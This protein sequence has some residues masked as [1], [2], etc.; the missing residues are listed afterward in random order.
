[1]S[2][3]L[4]TYTR[5]IIVLGVSVLF[6]GLREWQSGDAL[7]Y[8]CYLILAILASSLRVGLNTE[9]GSF[10]ISYLFILVGVVSLHPSETLALAAAV[11][12]TQF[13]ADR[14]NRP[15]KI[16]KALYA[17]SVLTIAT[18]LADTAVHTPLIELQINTPVSNAVRLMLVGCAFFVGHSFP[19]ATREAL[20]G[21]KNIGRIWKTEW[22][23]RLPY[24]M[25]AAGA[26][27]IFQ[28]ANQAHLWQVPVLLTP[29]LYLLYRSYRLYMSK[30]EDERSHAE[31]M[32]SLHLRTIEALALAIDAKD[33]T[34]HDH[35]KRVQI[36]AVE[37]AKELGLAPDELD[38]LRAASLLHDIGKLAVPEHIIS[39]PGKL[40][41]EEFERMKVHPVVG[42]EI[43][44]RVR[45]PYP[46]VPIVRHH[47]EKWDG[48]GYPDRLRGEQI[49]IGARIL[50]AVDCLDALAS[51]RQYRRALPLDQAMGIVVGEAGRSYDPRIVEILARR[52]VEFE[53]MAK[54]H[55]ERPF[56]L[57]TDIRVE[58]GDAPAAGFETSALS[59]PALPADSG[60]PKPAPEF[61]QQ[62]AAAREEGQALFELAQNLGNSLSLDDTL[63]VLAVRLKKL[64]PFDA[65]AVYLRRQDELVPEF[66]SG[67]NSRLFGS[68][69]IPV[70]QG[71]SGW[72]VENAKP[73]LNGNPSVE[74]GYL[75][76]PAKFSTLR[77][78]LAVPLEG[79]H[80]VVGVLALYH[81]ERDAYSKDHLRILQAI[82][83]KLSLAVENSLRFQ[84]AEVSATTDFLT[85]LPNSRSLFLHLD[86]ELARSARTSTPVA[87]LVCDLDEFKQVNDR[88]GHLEG[89]KLLKVI[90][91][92]LRGNCRQ[93]DYVARIGGDEFV[94]VLPGLQEDHLQ[95]RID[96]LRKVCTDEARMQLG[97]DI[98]ISIGAAVHPADGMDAES[99]LA[100]ADR[101]MY[102][103]KSAR[104]HSIQDLRAL[105]SSVLRPAAVVINQ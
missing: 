42:A 27:G 22:F 96:H 37:T 77:S 30:V 43:L 101:T 88:Y 24:Y 74:P 18:S 4:T 82:S 83:S 60:A 87:I 45:F 65:M 46:V 21:S 54:A 13:L 89:N 86:S 63:S 48:T 85:E 36:Y 67:E 38:A 23:W 58:A 99:L 72:V 29:I 5:L 104:V 61:L 41:P 17:V 93:Y 51:D 80:G 31:E 19:E 14:T 76:D 3:A 70:G 44:E 84:Q 68:L 78:A 28:Q 32:A 73:L 49:P 98:T 53:K 35:L 69:R 39:K 8:A 92:T 40:T 64:V 7:Q 15:L 55:S 100:A 9:Q 102:K 47:H 75:N 91:Q 16:E 66:V 79:L 57:S 94:L 97:L 103:A 62:I 11:G 1:M 81:G 59:L 25:G 20:E 33:H 52:Y 6:A 95:R 105:R 50:A 56:R 26:A 10:S 90:A 71:L 12:V 34:T 2:P